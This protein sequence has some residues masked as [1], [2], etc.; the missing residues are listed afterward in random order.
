MAHASQ[1]QIQAVAPDSP[2]SPV[3]QIPANALADSELTLLSRFFALLA[4]WEE[5]ERRP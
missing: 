2:D 3:V 1:S 5:K 4:E